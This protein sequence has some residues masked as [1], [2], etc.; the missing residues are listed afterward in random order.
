MPVRTR[1]VVGQ[2]RLASERPCV[3]LTCSKL[4]HFLHSPRRTVVLVGVQVERLRLFAQLAP[5]LVVWRGPS[6]GQRVVVP[7]AQVHETREGVIHS[8]VEA[9]DELEVGVGVLIDLSVGRVQNLFDQSAL[10]RENCP[11]TTDAVAGD[12]VLLPTAQLHG[13]EMALEVVV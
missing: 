10:A 8:A 6:A 11:W 4:R 12:I 9:Y 7:P 13:D 3:K 1:A 5:Q 2:S